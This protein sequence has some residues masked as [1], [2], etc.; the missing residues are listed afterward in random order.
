MLPERRKGVVQIALKE[1]AVA[2]EAMAR[3]T[4]VVL[5]RK[6][7]IREESRD[8]RVEH[9]RF[10][11][12]PT[13]EHQREDLLQSPFQGDLA[14]LLAAWGGPRTV[15]LSLWAEVVATFAVF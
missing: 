12:F 14:G 5:V 1:W 9:D 7:G 6:G 15:T 13:Y 10:L 2:V 11:L 3:G 8:F 4:Q